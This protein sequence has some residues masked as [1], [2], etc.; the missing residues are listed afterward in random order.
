ML[1]KENEIYCNCCGKKIETESY[2]NREEYLTVTKEW[3][4]FSNKDGQIHHIHLC[5]SCYDRW[6][7]QF[8]LPVT[9]K[10]QTEML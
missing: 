1:K 6:I 4:Y 10:E 9:V 5:E 8:V 3:G 2:K 7:K